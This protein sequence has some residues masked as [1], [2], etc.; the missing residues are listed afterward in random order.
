MKA[1]ILSLLIIFA[2]TLLLRNVFGFLRIMFSAK[3]PSS[4]TD[5]MMDRIKG[6]LIY[7]F[8]QKRILKNY[9]WA[10]IEHF[11]LFW[12]FM[13]IIAGSLEMLILGFKP[14]FEIF[15]FLGG[16]LQGV[17]LLIL[18]I[19]QALVILALVMGALNRTVIPSGKRREVNSIDAVVILGLIFGLMV[20]DFGFRAS[21]IAMGIESQAWLPISSIWASFFLSNVNVTTIAFTLEFFWWFYICLLLAFLNY[22]PY[23]KHSHVLTAAPNVFFQNLDPTGKMTKIDFENVPEDLEHFGTAKFEDFSWKDILDAYTCTECGRCTD[24]CPAWLTD[25][26]LSPRDIVIKLRHFATENSGKEEMKTDIL[27]SKSWITS[28]ELY[29]CT[30]CGACVEQCPLLID[31]MGKILEMRRY[32]TMEGKL[33]GAPVRTLQ[34]LQ[35]YG[36]PWG[37]ESSDRAPWAKKEGVPVLGNGAG[38]NAEDFDVIFWTGCFGAYDPRGQEVALTIAQ[39]LKEAGVKFAIMGPNETCSGD[40]ARRLGDEALYQELAITNV[41]TMKAFGVKKV[42]ANCP[43]CFNTLKN[44]YP[45]FGSDVEVVSHS[46]FLNTLIK[47]GKLT[48]TKNI[49]EEITYH[50]PCYLGRHNRVFDEPREI[51]TSIPGLEIKELDR[52][53]ENSFCCGAGGGKMWME[54]EAPRVNWNRFDEIQNLGVKTAAVACPFC[55]TMFEDAAKYYDNETI[56]IKDIAEILKDSLDLPVNNSNFEKIIADSSKLEKDD[57]TS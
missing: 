43:H 53:R 41:K 20:S 56:K 18:D 28:E 32:L 40:P 33:T 55:S 12:G 36:N 52:S 38:N 19:V 54:E 15:G 4:R 16:N 24:S 6:I 21:K 13:I 17:Y 57:N 11:M 30:T 47:E 37:F 29:A 23:S 3:K 50:D 34:K 31:Q 49:N 5:R 2:I 8:G 35:S 14:G 44:E 22:L 45:D 27:P 10:G 9:T 46:E 25:K 1:V 48:P 7:V 39:L 51:L 42:I 26:P